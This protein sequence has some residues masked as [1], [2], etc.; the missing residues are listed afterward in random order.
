MNS[1]DDRLEDLKRQ[2]D[3]Y[4]SNDPVFTEKDKRLIRQKIAAAKEKK[5]ARYSTFIP[6]AAA[7]L[8]AG[9][10][11]L[12]AG[13]FAGYQLGLLQ[14]E[15][16][17]LK[18]QETVKEI[19]PIDDGRNIFDP[20]EAVAGDMVA[21][22][23]LSQL[24]SEGR[25]GA[26]QTVYAEFTGEKLI[27]GTVQ[28]F[29]SSGGFLEG[30][31]YFKP[32]AGSAALLPR[33]KGDTRESWI[34]FENQE[35]FLNNIKTAAEEGGKMQV[36]ID[37]YTIRFAP[38]DSNNTA[39]IKSI[40]KN[41]PVI[42]IKQEGE[43]AVP[44]EKGKGKASIS[45]DS[46]QRFTGGISLKNLNP[47]RRYTITLKS[48]A[49]AGVVF[50]PAG[51][52]EIAEGSI[53]D[54]IYFIPSADGR[55]EVSMANPVRILEGGSEFFLIVQAEGDMADMSVSRPFQFRK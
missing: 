8:T 53:E 37:T 52:I 41:S 38:S 47:G 10:F 16:Q 32:D 17:S 18:Q 7:W 28:G 5:A 45:M 6:R 3:S 11:F 46:T 1:V 50:G 36:V 2:F 12:S 19:V 43:T 13:G 42:S 29:G 25:H 35:E 27:S 9:V 33:F 23:G 24:E 49:S 15:G 14:T 48:S 40:V 26:F 4:I 31:F 30:Q 55:L 44:M 20:E 54:E 22:M 34:T 39:R 21:G 51:N